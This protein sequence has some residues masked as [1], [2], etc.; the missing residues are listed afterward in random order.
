MSSIKHGCD[1]D[2][3]DLVDEAF[4]LLEEGD[5]DGA[6]RVCQHA[7]EHDQGN[8]EV[9]TL[10][11]CIACEH[12]AFT[13]ALD[14]FESAIQADPNHIVAL[15][16]IAEVYLDML[17]DPEKCLATC[18]RALPITVDDP[19]SRL[20]VLAYKALALMELDRDEEARAA[21]YATKGLQVGDPDAL[22][23]VGG[24]AVALEAWDVAEGALSAALRIDPDHADAHYGMGWVHLE[25]GDMAQMRTHWLRTLELDQAVPRPGW[26]LTTQEFD[27][28]AEKALLELPERARTLLRNVAIVVEDAPAAP[29]I[30]DGLDPRVL[31]LFCGAPLDEQSHM[32]PAPE[33]PNVI[34]LYQRNLEGACLSREELV[35][36]IRMT[37]LHETAHYFGL[38]D[39]ELEQIGLG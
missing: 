4:G 10:A 31:G 26:H 33:E 15:L 28:V 21:L 19:D 11:G 34:K 29:E 3:V 27:A 32:D 30:E 39:D 36:E 9:L 22:E 23:R 35:S 18:E 8:A 16:D 17:G 7:L 12:G 24:I 20:E 25:R 6:E 37:L 2:V 1:H 13:E 38:E 5:V 14:R